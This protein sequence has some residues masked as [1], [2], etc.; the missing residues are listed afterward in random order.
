MKKYFLYTVLLIVVS[1]SSDERPSVDCSKDGPTL[2]LLQLGDADCGVKNGFISVTA[3]GGNGDYQFKLD[4]GSFQPG[5]EFQ[6][7]GAGSYTITLR[8]GNTC[9][10]T[11]SVNVL[12]KDGVNVSLTTTSAGCNGTN[13]TISAQPVGGEGP[14]LFKLGDEDYREE[15]MFDGLAV[16]SYVVTIKDFTECE[17]SQTVR[18]PSGVSFKSTI[19]PIIQTSCAI[20]NCHNGRQFPDFRQF[21]N[22]KANADNIK[23]LTG[24]RTM[25]Q[26]GMLTQ[27]QIDAIA[28]WVDDGALD[29]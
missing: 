3:S 22:I 5:S 16:G 2:D 9:E 27:G 24:N 26:E 6:N 12:N 29:N 25:P 17:A 11:L 15:N 18:V 13:G 10:Q 21:N 1:C 19:E 4:N 8:D 23:R 7:L 14:F 20:N 28:C